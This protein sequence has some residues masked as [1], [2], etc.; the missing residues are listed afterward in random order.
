M[1]DHNEAM[2]L[3]WKWGLRFILAFGFCCLA[4]GIVGTLLLIWTLNQ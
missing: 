3:M 4:S 1:L 2:D